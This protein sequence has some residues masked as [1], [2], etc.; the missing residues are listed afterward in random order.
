MNAKCREVNLQNILIHF[1]FGTGYS[2]DADAC[3]I[4]GLVKEGRP[5]EVHTNQALHESEK[6][7]SRSRRAWLRK[8]EHKV[9]SRVIEVREGGRQKKKVSFTSCAKTLLFPVQ[10]KE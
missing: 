9:L 6:P 1:C 8:R 10:S 4:S 7:E 5:V 3:W 2:V